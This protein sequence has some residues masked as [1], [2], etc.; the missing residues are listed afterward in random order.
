MYTNYRSTKVKN[1]RRWSKAE[2]MVRLGIT[3]D[4]YGTI[5][6][7]IAKN[8]LTNKRILHLYMKDDGGFCVSLTVP[9]WVH[10]KTK[11]EPS[12][13]SQTAPKGSEEKKVQQ[14]T[15][16]S[17]KATHSVAGNYIVTSMQPGMA[18]YIQSGSTST[19]LANIMAGLSI[20]CGGA[21]LTWQICNIVFGIQD[22]RAAKAHPIMPTSASGGVTPTTNSDTNTL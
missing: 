14:P 13:D 5:A 15:Q 4:E 21:Y 16:Q 17:S 9:K 8:N 10:D 11:P 22:R 20:L 7:F 12:T 18:P 6:A 19:V 1:F 3:E 2:A